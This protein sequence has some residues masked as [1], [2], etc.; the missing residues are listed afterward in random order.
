MFAWTALSLVEVLPDI[1]NNLVVTV[2][3]RRLNIIV[4]L[5]LI[6]LALNAIMNATPNPILTLNLML[7]LVV[8]F[9]LF[10]T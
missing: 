8:I 7:I 9:N 3:L 4:I 10:S 2:T 1:I 6:T 5:T